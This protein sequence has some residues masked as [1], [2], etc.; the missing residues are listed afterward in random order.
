MAN[1]SPVYRTDTLACS[2]NPGKLKKIRG[3]VELMRTV[4]EREAQQQCDVL[5]QQQRLL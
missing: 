2:L 3:L 1:V 5:R 4:A